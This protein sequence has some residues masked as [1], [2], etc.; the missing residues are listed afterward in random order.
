MI[1][2]YPYWVFK[3]PLAY[4]VCLYAN[5]VNG[6]QLDDPESDATPQ[7]NWLVDTLKAIRKEDDRPRGFPRDPLSALF[8]REQFPRAQQSQSRPHA[9]YAGAQTARNNPAGGVRGG[10]ALPGCG[11]LRPCPSLSEADAISAPMGGRSPIS[12]LAAEAMRPLR[13][14]RSDAMAA[15]VPRLS[16]PYS[17]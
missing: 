1:Q 12:S 17:P 5:D 2:P 13:P 10:Q 16:F 9:A 11:F 6:G 7:F 15:S 3:T 4:F 8:G 14:W